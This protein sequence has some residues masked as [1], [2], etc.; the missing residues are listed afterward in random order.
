MMKINI[1]YHSEPDYTGVGWDR[2]YY[3]YIALVLYKP[4]VDEYV[5]GRGHGTGSTYE[6]HVDW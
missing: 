5:V 4:C 3:N 2:F 6:D 1:E